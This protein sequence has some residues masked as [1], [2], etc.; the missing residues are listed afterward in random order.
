MKIIIGATL[1][2]KNHWTDLIFPTLFVVLCTGIVRNSLDSTTVK[3]FL[4]IRKTYPF[5]TKIKCPQNTFT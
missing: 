5:S 4:A 2:V 3:Q 1:P